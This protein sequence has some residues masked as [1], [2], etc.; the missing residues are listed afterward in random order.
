MAC[1]Y[2][3]KAFDTLDVNADT[4]KKVYKIMPFGTTSVKVGRNTYSKGISIPC[5]KCIGCRLDYSREWAIRSYL[6]CKE[7]DYNYFVTLTYA[8]EH[9][10]KGQG[11]D[12]ET[13]EVIYGDSL[14][15]KHLTK[16]IKDLRRYFDY[17][18][19]H[20]GIRFMASGEYGDKTGRPHYHLIIYNLP[21]P[22]CMYWN[23][24]WDGDKYF[25]SKI[26][27][28]I[29]GKGHCIVANVNWETS[30][31]VARYVMKK[32][33]GKDSRKIYAARGQL[34]EFIR[35]SR[36][37]GL[38]RSYYEKNKDVIYATDELSVIKGNKLLTTRPVGY[39]DRLYEK[40]N[41]ER[42]A[43]LKAKRQDYAEYHD[44]L[45]LKKSELHKFDYY[46]IKEDNKKKSILY[47]SK[48]IL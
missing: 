46:K 17:H 14:N 15:P 1:Y 12:V 16:F 37:P 44:N 30:A 28:D 48:K 32:S 36:A 47:L 22:D 35:Q 8:P 10:P 39:F 34:P 26:I 25:T 27:S 19:G 40:D 3:L 24:N 33:L 20:K 45:I 13:G 41:P 2:P 9:L 38:G 31:Y 5:G 4:G 23:S 18:Y 7:Y 29:W 42:L 11:Y 21:L 43:E 6:E